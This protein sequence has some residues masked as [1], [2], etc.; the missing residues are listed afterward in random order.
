MH[1]AWVKEGSPKEGNPGRTFSKTE[2]HMFWNPGPGKQTSSHGIASMC[3]PALFM[4]SLCAL[5][6]WLSSWERLKVFANHGQLCVIGKTP[7]VFT[8][9]FFAHSR[10]FKS[11]YEF[12][13][14]DSYALC[15]GPS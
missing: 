11:S 10:M 15:T 4:P 1:G 8:R 5:C 14:L 9:C 13:V 12:I 6:R 3:A 2:K 7:S